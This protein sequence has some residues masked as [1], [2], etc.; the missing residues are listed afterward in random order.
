MNTFLFC[1]APGDVWMLRAVSWGLILLSLLTFSALRN[2][3]K[4]LIDS[5]ASF[6]KTTAKMSAS[7]NAEK[8]LLRKV[9]VGQLISRQVDDGA[10]VASALLSS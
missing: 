3:L 5:A 7:A 10:H 1:K 2:I 8:V 4:T 6:I 9:A